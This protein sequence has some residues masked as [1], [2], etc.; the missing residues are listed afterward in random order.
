MHGLLPTAD[1]LE[2]VNDLLLGES[3]QMLRDKTLTSFP[4]SKQ[5]ECI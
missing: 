5:L 1:G 2:R 3:G 4:G